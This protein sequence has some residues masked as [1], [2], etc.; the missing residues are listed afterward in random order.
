MTRFPAHAAVLLAAAVIAAP[1]AGAST[2]YWKPGSTFADY[3]T[4]SN[5]ST[6][7]V[8][9][10]D[11]AALPGSGD[12]LEPDADY[13]FDLGGASFAVGNWNPDGTKTS[14]RRTLSVRNGTLSTAGTWKPSPATITVQDG[15]RLS[16]GS[17]S[18]YYPGQGSGQ[19]CY[20]DVESGGYAEILHN[21]NLRNSV[22]NVAAGGELTFHPASYFGATSAAAANS[23][24]QAGIN[25]AGTLNLPGGISWSAGGASGYS[26][27]LNQTAGELNLGAGI[28]GSTSKRSLDY[29]VSF[30]GGTI[31]VTGDATVQNCK[32]ATLSGDTTW[33]VASG[34]TANLSAVSVEAGAS[35]AKAGTGTLV[36][37]S[38][39]DVFAV[40]NGTA[41]LSATIP[42]SSALRTVA[43][44]DGGTLSVDVSGASIA[45]LE[46]VKGTLALSK[47]NLTV[48]AVDAGATLSGSVTVDLS[49]FATGGTLVTTPSAALREKVLAA[50][51]A[52]IS[53]SGAALVASDDGSSVVLAPAGALKVFDSTAVTDLADAAG[54]QDGDIPASGETALVSGAGVVGTL[55]AAALAKGW[56]QIS[57]QNGA[58]LRLAVLP[59]ALPLV[60]DDGTTLAV[61]PGVAVGATLASSA[62]ALVLEPGA[63]LAL[64]DGETFAVSSAVTTEATAESLSEIRVPSGAVL[65][66]PDGHAFKNVSLV[67]DGGTL[68]Q[69]AAGTVTFGTAAADETAYF[70]MA[71]TNA[72]IR[73]AD[74][75]SGNPAGY[76]FACPAS[77]GE[78]V[79]SGDIV[80]KNCTVSGWPKGFALGENNP[81][82]D[83]FAVVL[84]N[85]PLTWYK[86]TLSISGGS[87]LVV[88]NGTLVTTSAYNANDDRF[89]I[90][91]AGQL[92]VGQGG[93]V[94]Y[95]VAGNGNTRVE[96][97]GEAP[98]RPAIV[99]DGG[100]FEPYKMS[101]TASGRTI[102]V[103][104]DSTWQ[105]FEDAYWWDGIRNI[106]FD[107]AA[108][109]EITSGATLTI[110][111]RYSSNWEGND[112]TGVWFADAPVA[113]AGDVV[114]T[115]AYDGKLF[116]A[117]LRNGANTCS[118]TIAALGERCTLLLTNGCNWAGTL[119]ANGNVSFASTT[120]ANRVALGG[121]RFDADLPLRLWAD[122]TCDAID[123][124]AAGCSGTGALSFV[125]GE[126]DFDPTTCGRK[127]NIG[128]IP[129]GADLPPLA[130][131]G[132][133]LATFETES[134]ETLGLRL[135]RVFATVMILR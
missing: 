119:V 17:G 127:W 48:S 79:V 86:G 29:Y 32:T 112:N 115:N 81:T 129:V 6:E 121:V 68:A 90:S 39:P 46:D 89:A 108:E 23:A 107:G 116:A 38:V 35:V 71:A 74:G 49:S 122:G 30:S 132:W 63:T 7:S 69:T 53:S 82:N 92:V 28:N 88:S 45:T 130:E 72:A 41:S 133:E 135:H 1:P 61:A 22:L 60:F 70:A 124:G 36:L 80:L 110:R 117:T 8:S 84:D 134:P 5:W 62:P 31:N 16:F 2:Y 33:N 44:R 125:A 25:N 98:D 114:L 43:V 15:G 26:A 111:N 20:L 103:A 21:Y 66:V 3:G 40:T 97:S 47:P 64:A 85:T 94:F 42:S 67:L 102:R 109:T 99:L 105:V 9:G 126:E 27:E 113:G 104:S 56:S 34:K 118:G 10:A 96:L 65:S 52:A 91:G 57:V 77:G 128:S 4:L 100:V 58:T 50:A 87:A 83:E 120:N 75:V 51:E 101:E 131:S 24:G 106:P 55:T 73:L 76:R 93:T 19:V 12:A 14:A 59:G 37:K 123:F 11:A 95:P 13:A 18:T 54:W 78:V